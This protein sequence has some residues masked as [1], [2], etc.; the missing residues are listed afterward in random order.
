MP[1]RKWLI[2][3]L[4]LLLLLGLAAVGILIFAAPGAPKFTLG[5]ETTYVTEPVDAEGYV[6]YVEALDALRR[7]G[8]VPE[9]NAQVLL[10]QALGPSPEGSPLGDEFFKRLGMERLPAEGDYFIGLEAFLKKKLA[11]G[12]RPELAEEAQAGIYLQPWTAK[13]RPNAAAW[14]AANA[15]PV[16]LTRQATLRPRCYCP[17]LNAP[18]AQRYQG[19][20]AVLMPMV[21]G[22]RGLANLLHAQAML[23][24][25]E[26]K[27]AEARADLVASLRLSRLVAQGPT[28]IEALVAYAIHG[29][30]ADA[31]AAWLGDA[32]VSAAE[33]A[34]FRDELSKLLPFPPLA[35]KI[36]LGERFM[37]LDTMLLTARHGMRYMEALAGGK[38]TDGGRDV[39]DLFFGGLDWDPALKDANVWM[40]RLVA[41]LRIEDRDERVKQI[42]LLETEIKKV[43]AALAGGSG[44]PS[45]FAR[46]FSA[47]SRVRTL[48]DLQRCLFTPA[49]L[50]VQTASDRRTQAER[51][52][53]VAVALA[54]H[55]RETGK[56]PERL[57][58]L[59]P[60]FISAVPTDLFSGKELRYQRE[61]AGCWF[62]SVGPNGKDDGGKSRED[63]PKSDDLPV[64][65][66]RL[67][68]TAES[69]AG[70]KK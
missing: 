64:R 53:Q 32:R 17:L 31:A 29:A 59:A 15:K 52:L 45:L 30:A 28:L 4:L 43:K 25:G 49:L 38:P 41:A 46:G 56:Y 18:T 1:K 12:Y 22:T 7:K 51:S 36:D 8:I 39:A 13:E 60:K 21:Q 58:E 26:G 24:L 16:E 6:D 44:A 19:L 33:I 65:L 69:P 40:D 2:G 3:L 10:M 62:W 61:G 42:D 11:D 14:L 48:G 23:N 57:S 27:V 9:Q 54:L 50:R 35:D 55:Q 67:P 20:M 5:K 37:L 66:P 47:E 63:D 34:R 70:E 68:Q